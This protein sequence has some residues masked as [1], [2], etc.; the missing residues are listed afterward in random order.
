VVLRRRLLGLSIS[1]SIALTLACGSTGDRSASDPSPVLPAHVEAPAIDVP[2]VEAPLPPDPRVEPS[3]EPSATPTDE[4]PHADAATAPPSADDIQRMREALASARRLAHASDWSASLTAYRE[5]L[6]AAPSGRVRCEA[7]FVA[8]RGGDEELAEEWIK[9]ALLELPP[10]ELADAEQRVPLAMCSYNAG[11]VLEA[12]G[13]LSEAIAAFDRSLV[14]RTN[15]TVEAARARVVEALAASS[16]PT[17]D[18]TAALGG[19]SAPCVPVAI[20]DCL[21]SCTRGGAPHDVLVRASLTESPTAGC[22]VYEPAPPAAALG[23]PAYEARIVV[24]APDREHRV[25]L[26]LRLEG[27]PDRSGTFL[28]DLGGSYPTPGSESEVVIRDASWVDAQAGGP[29]ELLVRYAFRLEYERAQFDEA[30]GWC[31]SQSHTEG[32]IAVLCAIF[33][34]R[35]GREL[36]CGRMLLERDRRAT[37]DCASDPAALPERP[38]PYSSQRFVVSMDASSGRVDL[39]LVE[40]AHGAGDPWSLELPTRETEQLIGD[41]EAGL[42]RLLVGRRSTVLVRPAHFIYSR[43]LFW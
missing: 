33:D 24:G 25:G 22:A 10:P 7:G 29:P 30:N 17:S 6:A 27:M 21:S 2:V 28:V 32:E 14:L 13:R 34:L 40:P 3:G 41:A 26:T 43:A 12:R 20:D 31:R 35:T 38:T 19:P 11:L 42:Q 16:G 1:I 37:R 36:V 15:G 5:A 4:A 8:H 23:A 9:Q 39:R 18:P